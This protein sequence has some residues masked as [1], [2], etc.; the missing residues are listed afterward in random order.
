MNKDCIS[1]VIITNRI[2]DSDW[3]IIQKGPLFLEFLRNRVIFYEDY[4]SK[5]D[6]G[7][8]AFWSV[9]EW[10]Q[11]NASDLWYIDGDSIYFYSNEDVMAF[12]LRWS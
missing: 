12:K 4:E 5:R 7:D 3:R 1:E 11:E 9:I 8:P 10:I 6:D 2:D